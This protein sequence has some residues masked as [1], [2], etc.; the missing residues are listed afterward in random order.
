VVDKPVSMLWLSACVTLAASL[1]PIGCGL[2][3]PWSRA[4]IPGFPSPRDWYL[5]S[6]EQDP[7]AG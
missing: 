5:L 6:Y 2:L 1:Y 7:T 3:V 4:D